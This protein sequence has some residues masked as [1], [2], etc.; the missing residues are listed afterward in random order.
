LE[1]IPV[2]QL[3]KELKGLIAELFAL[4]HEGDVIAAARHGQTA[5]NVPGGEVYRRKGRQHTSP[6]L[7]LPGWT[8]VPLTDLGKQ[9]A[10]DA[11]LDLAGWLYL[12]DLAQ[13]TVFSSNLLRTDQ[14]ARRLV[15][16][17]RNAATGA[18][19]TLVQYC[20]WLI[21]RDHG[22]HN[23][24]LLEQ[25]RDDIPQAREAME[26][27]DVPFPG[28]GDSVLW[29]A[30]RTLRGLVRQA[31]RTKGA[32]VLVSHMPVLRALNE[33]LLTGALTDNCMTL[34]VPNGSLTVARFRQGGFELIMRDNYGSLRS[35]TRHVWV[36]KTRKGHG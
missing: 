32:I 6:G 29:V 25:V 30:V 3:R 22:D 34:E 10:D 9:Q 4:M 24:A 28:G 36:M 35:I 21:D 26:H 14:T 5:F 12:L 27:V 15:K 13:A 7:R 23:G 11:G 16:Q 8:P 19:L 18:D 33:I 20:S 17:A 1:E 31:K 2:A